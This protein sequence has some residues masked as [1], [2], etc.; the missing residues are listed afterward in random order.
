VQDR[1]FNNWR[2]TQE[3]WVQSLEE[4]FA[5]VPL[6]RVPLFQDEVLGSER[7]KRL[8]RVLY[9]NRDPATRFFHEAPYRFGKV[10]GNYHLRL[11]LPFVTGEDVTL[12]KKQDELVI[13]VGSFKRHVTLPQR[14]GHCEPL[15]AR[16]RDGEL[17]VVLG[18]NDAQREKKSES[19]RST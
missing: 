19:P 17:V 10:D 9:G 5:P 6:W 3:R 16:I 18:R 8:G 13:R 7:L 2:E 4:F 11:R 12:H 1:F 14:M 15:S